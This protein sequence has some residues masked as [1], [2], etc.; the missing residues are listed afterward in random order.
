MTVSAKPL[1]LFRRLNAPITEFY[2]QNAV[3]PLL[4]VE[5]IPETREALSFVDFGEKLSVIAMPLEIFRRLNGQITAS[6][7]QNTVHAV[8]TVETSPTT[9]K[10]RLYVVFNEK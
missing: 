7:A 2:P 1:E 3:H 5:T 6:Y 4:S 10:T 9:R 8:S